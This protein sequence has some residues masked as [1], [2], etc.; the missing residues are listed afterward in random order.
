VDAKHPDRPRETAAGATGDRERGTVA[1][2]LKH[3][4]DGAA[5]PKVVATGRGAVAE[6][7]LEI[8][9]ANGV[10]VRQDADLAEILGSIELDSEI[11]VE[12]FAA[13]AEILAYVY[14]ANRELYAPDPTDW[15]SEEPKQP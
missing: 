7:I 14:R 3:G 5:A 13:V 10:R 8:A 11:P 6:Q 9:F 2:A 15:T 4:R 1:V 12:V